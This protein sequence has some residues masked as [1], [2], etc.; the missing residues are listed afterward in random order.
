MVS[1]EQQ[2]RRIVDCYDDLETPI[3]Y[4]W[5]LFR[6][7]PE[8]E[9]LA[10]EIATGQIFYE[11]APQKLSLDDLLKAKT[12]LEY[13]LFSAGLFQVHSLIEIIEMCKNTDI[14]SYYTHNVP[15]TSGKFL[16]IKHLD[17]QRPI[18]MNWVQRLGLK[19]KAIQNSNQYLSKKS[20]SIKSSNKQ[21][22]RFMRVL[23]EVSK[24]WRIC[25][26]ENL[27]FAIICKN[28]GEEVKVLIVKDN[29]FNLKVELPPEMKKLQ[30]LKVKVECDLIQMPEVLFER[31][32]QFFEL[33][34]AEQV[35]IDDEVMRE[36]Q[37]KVGE[38]KDYVMHKVTRQCVEFFV[39]VRHI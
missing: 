31:K 33:E 15:N 18:Q 20:E 34:R 38:S 28:S 11:D 8:S 36:V 26:Q 17:T 16:A 9:Q 23:Q 30:I 7:Q 19:Y 22:Q 1:L 14:S 3:Y 37:G 24:R 21:Q 35:L 6:K 13:F 2:R 29:E 25:L 32:S 39:N 5:F 4:E 27:I 12:S 10:E